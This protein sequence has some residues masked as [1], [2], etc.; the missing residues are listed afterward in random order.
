M[1]KRNQTSLRIPKGRLNEPVYPREGQDKKHSCMQHIERLLCF[2]QG[3][4]RAWNCVES[5]ETRITVPYISLFNSLRTPF[6]SGC[7]L[8]KTTNWRSCAL[9][10]AAKCVCF[11]ETMEGPLL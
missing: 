9:R 11:E 4:P 3:T 6:S 7:S 5:F 2:S 8:C 1:G 10:I